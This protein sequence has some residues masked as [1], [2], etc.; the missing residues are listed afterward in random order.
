M[1]K[2]TVSDNLMFVCLVFTLHSPSQIIIAWCTLVAGVSKS[3]T[4]LKDLVV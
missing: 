4:I 1:I 2:A 3:Q